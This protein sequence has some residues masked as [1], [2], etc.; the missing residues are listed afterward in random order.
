MSKI[1]LKEVLARAPEERPFLVLA[2][3]L[4]LGGQDTGPIEKFLKDYAQKKSALPRGTL[5]AGLTLPQSPSGVASLSPADIFSLLDRKGLW[6][7]L[8]VIPH[9][10]AKDHNREGL[11]ALLFGLRQLGLEA[12]LAL[13]GDKP[14]AGKGVFEVDAVG[15]IELIKDMN[16]ESM[17]QAASAEL[18]RAHQFTILAAVS[19]FKY[20]EASLR[21]QY[22]KMEKKLRAGAEALVTQ[23]GWDWRKSEELFRYLEEEHIG[24][25]VFGNVYLL[26][27]AT[28]AP[29]LMREGKLPGCL[30]T[31]E[32]FQTLLK[33]R[34][35]DHLER[36]AVQV[37]MYRDL[38]AAGVDVGGVFD[39][40]TLAR[41]MAR[42]EEIGAGWRQ[43]QASLDFG[44]KRLPDGRPGFYLYDQAGRRREPA[45]PH[46]GLHK[47]FFDILH[48]TLLTPG[49]GLQPALKKLL[50]SSSSLRKGRGGL[51]KFFF[52]G[53][54]AAKTVL[55]DCR[56][57]GDCF[58]PE[59]F[60]RCTLGECAKGLPNP[61]CGDADPEGKCSHDPSRRCV[62]ELIWEA[63]ASQG[64]AGLA[65]LKKTA[66]PSRVAAL[67]G[68]S[69]ILNNLFGKDHA[70][71]FPLIQIGENVHA[72][73]P[74]MAAAMKEL[75]GR[76]P[77]ALERPSGA[78][79]YVIAQ[80]K[81]QVRHQ[82]DYI[83]INVDAFGES[84]QELRLNM[85]RDYVRL[86]RRQSEGVPVSV[87]SASPA[88]LKAGLEAWYEGAQAL[89]PPLLNSVKTYTMDELLPLRSRCPFKFV[90]LL[91]DIKSTG[92]QASYYSV[93]ELQALARTL[94]RAAVGRHGFKP[95][96]IFFDSTVF[97]LAIDMPL[98]A[99]APGYT[100]RTF[101]T[102]RRIKRDPEMKGVHCSL[103]ITNAVR[104][105]PGRKTGV[106]RAYLAKAMEYGLDAAIVNVLHDYGQ[107]PAAPDLMAFVDA[108]ARQDGSAEAQQKAISAMMAF[109]QANRKIRVG[110]GLMAS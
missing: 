93:E 73:I 89:P 15:L 62:G 40:D 57:C 47:K 63:A 103:G 32:L 7:D 78:L 71:K 31:A 105:L 12:V 50:R 69:S 101:E 87:D 100:F 20:T 39:F 48:R 36:A 37:A 17:L 43:S 44:L 41:I 109:C 75:L 54:K 53:E 28:P 108:F 85:M 79:D 97:P 25:P 56:E 11:R 65:A 14:S 84:D 106:C 81:A 99:E 19:P 3:F 107:R 95:G 59:N 8:E 68:T 104:D 77:G 30:V 1:R 110:G 52:A 26:S 34:P 45:P 38:G 16:L 61:P 49:R 27:T 23:M 88:V 24:L 33:E 13:T 35:A 2:E 80:I 18:D 4:P 94:H 55:Y 58:L 72:S 5:L 86:I 82:A 67:D 83:D 21:Q 66:N 46:P 29:R 9:V 22:L 70:A 90:G 60:G 76:G 74:R 10:T 102:I 92:S 91:V 42:A 98:S 6:A 64:P 96:D 51:Y